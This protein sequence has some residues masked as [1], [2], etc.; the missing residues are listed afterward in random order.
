MQDQLVAAIAQMLGL[1]LQPSELQVLEAQDTENAAAKALYLQSRGCLQDFDKA[2][3][4]DRALSGFEGTLEMDP[5]YAAAAAGIGEAYGRTFE[6]SKETKWVEAAQTACEHALSLDQ[7][8]AAAHGCLG[9]VHQA[10]GRY[11]EAVSEFQKALEVEPT[12]DNFIR[13]LAGA[14]ERLGKPEEA[15]NTC[16]RAI[17]FSPHYWANY[18][19]L[20]A[21]CYAQARYREAAAMF[22]QV[23]RLA[24]DN[25]FGYN[26]LGGT[27]VLL[28][29]YGDAIPIFDRSVAIRLT[30]AAHSNLATA[31]FFR[32]RFLEAAQ[33]FEEGV[34]L[35]QEN[36]TILGNL[37]DAYCWAPGKRP[38]AADAYRQAISLGEERLTITPRDVTVL[39]QVA[40]Y[41]AMIGEKQAALDLYNKHL[42]LHP[43]MPKSSSK[44]R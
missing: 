27:Y 29:Q 11:E 36:C 37:E 17:T 4:I 28:G 7:H 10:T 38:Q 14:Q 21:F 41:Y 39:G 5:S 13:E 15:E 18:N 22:E 2:E 31:Y 3:N 23:V 40:G 8:L 1:E 6:S 16:Q 43:K 20:G 19:G 25:V 30:A 32:R 35:S 24:S 42:K 33:S 34:K 9:N 26:N 12:N 44:Q